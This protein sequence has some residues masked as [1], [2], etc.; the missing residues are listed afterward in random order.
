MQGMQRPQKCWSSFQRCIGGIGS[1]PQ[2][3]HRFQGCMECKRCCLGHHRKHK[4]RR[5]MQG[6]QR[7]QK[8]W[9]S[10]QRCIGGTGS[11]L[12]MKSMFLG[13]TEC[14]M[15]SPENCRQNRIR[16]GMRCMKMPLRCWSSFQRCIKG[17]GSNP[18]R[19]HTN[20]RCTK[21]KMCSPEHYREHMIR[22]GIACMK[23]LLKRLSNFQTCIKGTGLSLPRLKTTLRCTGNTRSFPGHYM[24][25]MTQWGM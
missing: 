9:S 23:M 11:T 6:M 12:L 13:Y 10:F 3:L 24:Q 7:P 4:I 16:S 5:G 1:N 19:L 22:L 21:C 8:C 2:R 25:K 15:C 14:K 17:T 18:Q 20:L